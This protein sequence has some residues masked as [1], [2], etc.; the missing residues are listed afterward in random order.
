MTDKEFKE[1]RDKAAKKECDF[2]KR[3][4]RNVTNSK[5]KL[6]GIQAYEWECRL[7]FKAGAAATRELYEGKHE[8]P[9]KILESGEMVPLS[10]DKRIEELDKKHLKK[11]WELMQTIDLLRGN[12]RVFEKQLGKQRELER[13]VDELG[14]ALEKASKKL[15]LYRSQHSGNYIGGMEYEML[16]SIIVIALAK[17]KEDW[18]RRTHEEA[19]F[20]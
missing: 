15:G 12:I 17:A 11:R 1:W 16:Q 5:G 6:A 3:E 20:D 2:C 4:E 8:Q 13:T 7:A 9:M 10:H 18:L 14:E 19:E